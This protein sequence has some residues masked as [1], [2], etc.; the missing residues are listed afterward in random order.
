MVGSTAHGC[1]SS[2]GNHAKQRDS[3][4]GRDAPTTQKSFTLFS[5]CAS[6]CQNQSARAPQ[7]ALVSLF[8]A[9]EGA[10]EQASIRQ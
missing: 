5:V 1:G 8:E 6:C 3:S 7:E 10:E 9:G 2:A 4:T